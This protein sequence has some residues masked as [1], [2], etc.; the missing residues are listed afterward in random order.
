MY[1]LSF[2]TRKIHQ[3]NVSCGD[4]T[5]EAANKPKVVEQN[6]PWETVPS[7]QQNRCLGTRGRP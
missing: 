3:N 7:A 6:L 1:A 2:S 4:Q 5:H